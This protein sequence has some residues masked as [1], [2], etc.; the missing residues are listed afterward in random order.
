MKLAI[1]GAAELG[2]LAAY[3]AVNDL[4]YD[5]VGFY[6]DFYDSA[7]FFNYPILGRTDDIIN[8]F[9]SNKFDKLFI[10]IGY[11]RMNSRIAIFEQFK[12]KIP[13]S[14]II[15][16]SCYIDKSCKMGEGVFLLPR[17]VL[18]FGVEL[19]DNVLLNTGV[20]VAHHTIIDS[21]TFVS[22]GVNFAG[23][24]T[25]GKGCFIGIGT[26][27]KDSINI[28]NGSI[29]GA[30]SVVINDTEVNSISVGIPAK[31]IKYHT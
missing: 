7:T 4:G 24:I 22:P 18:D 20:V 21:H 1:I 11:N 16:S 19:G 10:G 8:D 28:A 15:H 26:T 25:V 29:I 13:F 2:K 9:A 30:G 6:D 17:T 14:S 5:L 23:L 27:I 3:H 31:C 12:D